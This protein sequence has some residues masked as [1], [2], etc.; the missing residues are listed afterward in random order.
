MRS[1]QH[2]LVPWS[3]ATSPALN[4]GPKQRRG[5]RKKALMHDLATRL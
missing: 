4:G 5:L 3:M 2:L 1:E